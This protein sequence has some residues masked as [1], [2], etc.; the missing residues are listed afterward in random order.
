MDILRPI[1]LDEGFNKQVWKKI[2]R[3]R[4]RFLLIAL[5]LSLFLL[6]TANLL[7][8]KQEPPFVFYIQAK[9]ANLGGK[10]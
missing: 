9:S 3:R 10:L 4:G 5:L 6:F 8:P 7:I 1:S 2:R